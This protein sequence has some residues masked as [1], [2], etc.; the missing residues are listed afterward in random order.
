MEESDVGRNNKRRANETSPLNNPKADKMPA[1]HSP[2]PSRSRRNSTGEA[3]ITEN[4]LKSML[5]G[6]E[7]RMSA[8]LEA[9]GS[10]VAKNKEDIKEIRE[11]L[12]NTETNLLERMDGQRR[13]L[14]SLIRGAGQSSSA[15]P[16]RLSDKCEESYWLNRRSLSIWP[17]VGEDLS[18]GIR[19]FLIQKL[20][21]SE[22]QVKDLGRI[23]VRRMKEPIPKARREAF[24]TFETKETRDLVKA[25]GKNLAGEGRE[26]GMRAQFPGF[27]VDT[28][29]LF[30]TIA[31]NLRESD[32]SIKRAVKYNDAEMDL[33]M[34]VKVGEEWR[35]IRPAEARASLQNNPKIKRGP[36]E[37]SS[38]D[39]DQLLARPKNN[40]PAS[41]A[42]ATPM[43]H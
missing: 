12:S 16:V 39:L 13:Q 20:K 1:R 34:D 18:S 32:P 8:K 21:F 23:A 41:G 17:I 30:E 11:Q 33:I 25:A 9:T 36:E 19:A 35:R 29:R 3:P 37:M 14:E 7:S 31:F 40:T 5:E 22:Q 28:F 4:L 10:G 6:L 26:V 38:S 24:C 43:N 42:N 15:G 27:L 2:P